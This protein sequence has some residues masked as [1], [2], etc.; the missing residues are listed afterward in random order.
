MRALPVLKVRAASRRSAAEDQVLVMKRCVTSGC[1]DRPG[2]YRML[3]RDGEVLYVGKSKRVRSRLLS[4][5]RCAFPADKGARLL[6]EAH[7]IEWE[8]VPS[9]FAAL[10][11]ELRLIKTLRPR[12]NV[13]LKRD[14]RHF[15]F[16]KV[17]AGPASKLLVVR[18]A[19]DDTAA[20][21]YGPFFGAQQLEEAVRELS[22]V[23]GL[24]DC[25][26]TT[27]MHFAD[28]QELFQLYPRTPG[29]I[30]HEIHKCLG[31]CVGGCSVTQYTER[32]ALAKAFLDGSND[33]PI[34]ILRARMVESSEHL[35][36]ERA[37]ILRDKVQRLESLRTQFLRFRFAV[38]SLSFI[39]AVPGHDGDDRVYFIRRGRVRAEQPA[40]RS[41]HA[42]AEVNAL[43]EEIFGSGERSG[44]QVPT[45]E[46]D[47]LLLTTSWFRRFPD[48]LGRTSE[49]SP[50][51]A[52]PKTRI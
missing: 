48:E 18:G 47:E 34:A 39:Y 17:T 5:F 49:F 10:L 22:D 26:L 2:V 31:P 46:I 30:R 24:R 6:R 25:A 41:A 8:Y 11:R 29:C 52:P 50:R 42:R 32:V 20:V 45:H 33:G 12:F 27:H 43:A 38:E 19:S 3:S 13:A 7:Q 14:A 28:Q 37:G 44:A 21:Y 4:Y 16:I 9:E 23:L 15:A 36:F 35:E 40:P 51:G 1:M